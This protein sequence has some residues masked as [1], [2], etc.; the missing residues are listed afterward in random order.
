MKRIK[1]RRKHFRITNPLGFSLFCASV[2]L[3]VAL[4]AGVVFLAVGGYFGD[5]LKC[6]KAKL[7]GDD[8][9]AP[10]ETVAEVSETP[11]FSAEP[12]GTAQGTPAET[13]ETGTP[14]PDTPTP[15]PISTETDDPEHSSKPSAD[16][17][18]PLYGYTIGIDPVRDGGS[19]YKA[20]CAYNL[21]FAQQLGDF[22]ESKG[23]TVVLTR[24]GNKKSVSNSTR[25]KTIK[26]AG[27]DIAIRLMCNEIAAKSS[28][29]YVVAMKKNKDYGQSLIDAYAAATG[30]RKQ[31]G[32]SNGL[33]IKNDDVSKN[34]G[35]PCVWLVMGNWKNKGD[36]SILEDDA[37]RDKMIRAIY[38]TIQDRLKN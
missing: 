10:T 7:N 19:T 21:E 15:P 26:N 22:L 18:A 34:C 16:P 31:A 4:I 38:E 12:T 1:T 3:V 36:R 24:D 30:I 23:A 5:A 25:A 20:E 17:N 29:C 13:P 33:Q 28:G 14:V 9:I 11:E 6:I 27:C 8:R 37:Y 32:K 2:I 35:C